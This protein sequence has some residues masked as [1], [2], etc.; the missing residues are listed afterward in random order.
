MNTTS[1]T[2]AKS[3]SMG[4]GWSALQVVQAV[5]IRLGD[6]RPA[7]QPDALGRALVGYV[8]GLEPDEVWERGRGVWTANLARLATCALAVITYRDLVVGM[9]TVEAVFPSDD[10]VFID[11]RI[12][13]KHPLLGQPDPL[14]NT[15]RNPIRTA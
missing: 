9:G 13:T 4:E 5:R 12:M 14:L 2:P 10:R 7:P 15:S 11:G 6:E 8:E 1:A 3:P